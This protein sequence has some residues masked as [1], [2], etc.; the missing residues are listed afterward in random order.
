[1]H[2]IVKFDAENFL[3]TFVGL[4]TAFVLGTLIGTER[5]YR[6]RTAGLRTNALVAVG[7]AGFVDLG[8][9]I[10]ERAGSVQ[11]LA[12]VV[13]GIGFLGAGVIMKEG[14]NVRGL[15][16]AATLWCSAAV[17]T[18][19]GTGYLAEAVLLTAFVLAG[20]TFLRPLVNMINRVPIN[21]RAAEAT[22]QVSVTAAEDRRDVIRDQLVER[23]EEA[24]HPI[25]ELEVIDRDEEVEVVATLAATSVEAAE[26]DGVA[27]DLEKLDGVNHATWTSTSA[28]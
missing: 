12:Y 3:G 10:N 24:N 14:L 17:G 5:Q 20:N 1:M 16:T 9:T 4:A 13:S 28:E 11:V 25:R 18:F 2:P 19:S 8:M 15:N 23:L 26:L 6:Q 27:H 7:A 21:E 22:Y